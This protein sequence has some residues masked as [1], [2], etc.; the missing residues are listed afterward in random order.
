MDGQNGPGSNYPDPAY[1]GDRENM[2]Q[3]QPGGGPGGGPESIVPAAASTANS[4]EYSE[5]ESDA[6]E[7]LG[8]EASDRELSGLE[9]QQI[10]Q[11][12]A[13]AAE[14]KSVTEVQDMLAEKRQDALDR[15]DYSEADY[16]LVTSLD[17]AL[18]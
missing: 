2:P 4:Y 14:G 17:P 7:D 16:L 1:V 6:S 3:G 9:V 10:H 15:R 18:V 11:E 8:S 5:S 13:R 12:L